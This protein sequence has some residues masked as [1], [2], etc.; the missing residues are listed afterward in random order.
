MPVLL[1]ALWALN[2]VWGSVNIPPAEV[3]AILTGGGKPG[4]TM[5]YI[6]LESRVPQALT[7]LLSGSALAVSGLMLQAAFRNPLAG[8]P[9]ICVVKVG[10][11]S[12]LFCHT[13][14]SPTGCILNAGKGYQSVFCK[15][16]F[17]NNQLFPLLLFDTGIIFSFCGIPVVDFCFYHIPY[18][19][20]II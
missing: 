16:T 5:A 11:S 8:L 1:C 4:S 13:G 19:K 7:A 20:M 3:F 18:T 10:T 9:D 6:V 15:N 2:V 17:V 12:I 14:T